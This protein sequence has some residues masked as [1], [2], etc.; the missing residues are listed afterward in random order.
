MPAVSQA[1]AAA[2]VTLPLFQS[3]AP[4]DKVSGLVHAATLLAR[5]LGQGRALDARALRAA[6]ETAFA[7]SDAEGAWVWKDAYEALEAAQVLFLRKYGAAMRA[8]AGSPAAMLDMLARLAERL[9]SQTRR[10]EESERLQQFSTPVTLGFVAAEAAALTASDLVLEPSAGTGLLAIFAELAKARLLLN[11]IAETRAGLLG[12]LFRD[13][14]PVTRHNAEHI[15]DRLAPEIRPTVVL[16]NPPFSASPD[17]GKRF[18]EAGFRHVAS[19]LARLAPG[20]RLVAITGHN[21]GPEEPGWRQAFVRLQERARVVFTAAI[22]GRAYARHGTAMDTRLTVIDRIPA[23]DQHHF[24][25][26]PGSAANAAE[27]LDYVSRLVPPRPAPAEAAPLP[28]P[29]VFALR[30]PA[31]RP[32]APPLALVK[33]PAAAPEYLP[34]PDPGSSSS[35]TRPR[36]GSGAGSANGVRPRADGS[37]RA[38]TR[39]TRC[40]RSVYRMPA[41][42]RQSSCSRR[43][44]PRSPLPAPPTGRTC[45]RT[46]CPTASCR[47]RSSRA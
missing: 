22:A 3:Q 27:L 47:T 43:R 34:G 20:G 17:V 31:A 42:I 10:S 45:R 44:W 25:S 21:T 12:R 30:A 15:H 23:E 11:E 2:A 4:I 26:S 46:C 35:I 6:M 39:A 7:G 33:T 24:P 9:P 41:R 29:A 8:R 28:A 37:R 40:N 1:A 36:I 14:A 16:M 32:K 18:A 5:S 38:S 19:A 13:A